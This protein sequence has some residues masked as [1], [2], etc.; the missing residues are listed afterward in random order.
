MGDEGGG[1]FGRW[2]KSLGK[3][4]KALG[5]GA[6]AKSGGGGDGD[7]DGKWA[8]DAETGKVKVKVEELPFIGDKYTKILFVERHFEVRAG[9]DDETNMISAFQ[10]ILNIL[11]SDPIHRTL[12]RPKLF[13]DHDVAQKKGKE[14]DPRVLAGNLKQYMKLCIG[15]YS[16]K[17]AAFKECTV[18]LL[19]IYFLGACNDLQPGALN[20]PRGL[21]S[22]AIRVADEKDKDGDGIP[23]AIQEESAPPPRSQQKYPT[24]EVS[25]PRHAELEYAVKCHVVDLLDETINN[26]LIGYDRFIKLGPP[27]QTLSWA[28]EL[29]KL[30]MDHDDE[31]TDYALRRGMVRWCWEVI[32]RKTRMR[33]PS[34]DLIA[35]VKITCVEILCELGKQSINVTDETTEIGQN[36]INM[37]NMNSRSTK[38]VTKLLHNH[39][40]QHPLLLSLLTMLGQKAENNKHLKELGMME[41]LTTKVLPYH[42]DHHQRCI[43]H[44]VILLNS[45]I[46][47]PE[48]LDFF[49]Q[50]NG[51]DCLV[52]HM[53][54]ALSSEKLHD[55]VDDET[56]WE[57]MILHGLSILYKLSDRPTYHQKMMQCQVPPVLLE[58]TRQIDPLKSLYHLNAFIAALYSL[59]NLTAGNIENRRVVVQDPHFLIL[60]HLLSSTALPANC[61]IHLLFLFSNL[62]QDK[63]AEGR[64]DDPYRQVIMN[65]IFLAVFKPLCVIVQST[66]LRK[67]LDD[68]QIT[69]LC[70]G[71]QILATLVAI[72]KQENPLLCIQI[73]HDLPL[74][75]LNTF[76][77]AKTPTPYPSLAHDLLSLV[78]MVP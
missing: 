31:V 35:K 27:T 47:H 39:A 18:E 59:R 7:A 37:I 65:D 40:R 36:S 67:A 66:P 76:A 48:D 17:N 24:A 21:E 51:I 57:D 15:P 69:I 1:M 12:V 49:W 70:L 22:E 10:K 54:Q 44:L 25:R 63:N 14:E 72:A 20:Q 58:S 19:A 55:K 30:L 56:N 32:T 74:Q 64:P 16:Q 77:R 2:G 9:S 8:A 29:Y 53:E 26:K 45:W 68:S 5:T 43:P 75:H 38:E 50:F 13:W 78:W 41:Y 6:G 3:I 73:E 62:T 61:L 34:S 11:R 23:D 60:P 28:L 33:E 46:V 4:S 52:F 71:L 42:S